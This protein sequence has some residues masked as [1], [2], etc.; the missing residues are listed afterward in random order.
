MHLLENIVQLSSSM[1]NEVPAK[2]K[3][4]CEDDERHEF[5]ESKRQAK[6]VSG[7]PPSPTERIKTF[8][9][10]GICSRPGNNMVFQQSPKWFLPNT[11]TAW[12]QGIWRICVQ[13]CM[14]DCLQSLQN[15]N[16][17]K[18]PIAAK[19]CI[20]TS[21]IPQHTLLFCPTR[22]VWKQVEWQQQKMPHKKTLAQ[23]SSLSSFKRK[24]KEKK[25]KNRPTWPKNEYLQ[26]TLTCK[27]A[28]TPSCS[29]PGHGLPILMRPLF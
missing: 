7:F 3:C 27:W 2:G 12:S 11:N 22:L 25:R 9:Q 23:L 4:D 20:T 26:H 6:S 17:N 24:K 8:R 28:P 21:K 29:A 16:L 1:C 5:A 18:P 14:H 10:N 13:L 15:V 19:Q